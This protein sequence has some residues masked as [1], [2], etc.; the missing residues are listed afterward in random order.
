MK[1]LKTLT[2]AGLLL[3][4]A[5][6][7]FADDGYIIRADPAQISALA[8]QFR[9][10]VKDI[11]RGHGVYLVH[12]AGG[13]NLRRALAGHSAVA[14]VSQ[15]NNVQLPETINGGV[16]FPISTTQGSN[17]NTRTGVDLKQIPGAPQVPG[18]YALPSPDL[19]L[20]QPAMKKINLPSALF[21]STVGQLPLSYGAGVRIAVID[22]WVDGGNSTLL[23]SID[24]PYAFDP[25][26]DNAPGAALGTAQETSP[27]IDQ[28]TSP[29]IDQETSP[30]IDSAATAMVNQETSPFI[31]QETSPFIDQE[32]SP[33]I[34][35]MAVA[36]GH[37]TM[38]AGVIH[39][40]A[41]G[42]KIIPI[43]A[44][45]TTGSAAISDVIQGI[46]YAVD[47]A[48]ADVIS[49]SF[50]SPTDDQNLKDAINYA[51]QKGVVCVASV[52]NSNSSTKVYPAGDDRVI[53][54]AATDYN[55]YKASFSDYGEDVEIAGPGTFITTT[56]PHSDAG[57]QHWAMASGTSFSTP[58]V[59]ATVALMK[60]LTGSIDP[61]SARIAL[62]LSADP[63]LDPVFR[64]ALG[65]GRLDVL[66]AL[67]AAKNK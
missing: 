17:G 58:A 18:G 57:R 10:K 40:I 6:A 61:N 1:K 12:S 2:L 50:S 32:T 35:G 41:P 16:K 66:G 24:A 26:Q 30:F 39:R 48:R 21:P 23:N 46:Y 36:Y 56:F 28:E 47:V 19:Y 34:D 22:T 65:K 59:A 7:V 11:S 64:N 37:G 13:V 67:N 8:Q 63:I 51:Q 33:F 3:M 29:F 9:L 14:H 4:S 44:F 25:I 52:S 20:N 43:R 53:G 5:S 62:E 38:V 42:A 55:D 49:M 60:S 27:F 45:R 31:D 15:N 54:V